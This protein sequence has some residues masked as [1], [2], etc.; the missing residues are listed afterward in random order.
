MAPPSINS[1]AATPLFCALAQGFTFTH[2]PRDRGAQAFDA[3][4]TAG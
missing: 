2:K 4:A 3:V 1:A